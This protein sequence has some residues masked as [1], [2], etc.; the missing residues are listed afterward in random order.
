MNRFL[1]FVFLFFLCFHTNLLAQKGIGSAKSL[2]KLEFEDIYGL[3]IS[4]NEVHLEIDSIEKF[5]LGTQTNWLNSHL[6]VTGVKNF[7]IGIKAFKPFFQHNGLE[8]DLSVS[9]ILVNAK[10]NNNSKNVYLSEQTQILI[11]E[12]NGSLI[13]NID[14]KYEIPAQKISAFLNQPNKTFETI[15]LY[16]LIPN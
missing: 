4:Q 9:N 2:I 11:I 8:T 16:T 5:N 15:I 14:I 1:N 10:I 13:N 3:N 7:E 6:I 12:K